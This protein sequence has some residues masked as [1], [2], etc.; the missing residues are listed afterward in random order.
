[1][2]M[3][4]GINEGLKIIIATKYKE[5]SVIFLD[6]I[7]LPI[8]VGETKGD[9]RI[10]NLDINL[11]NTQQLTEILEKLNDNMDRIE[12]LTIKIGD[13]ETLTLQPNKD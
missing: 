1:M 10:L 4:I 7:I 13:N 5:N 11:E 6:E 3:K 12:T 8:F 9:N 2:T